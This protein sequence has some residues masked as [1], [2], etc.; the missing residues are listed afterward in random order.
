MRIPVL[1]IYH[2]L[3][4]SW[5]SLEQAEKVRVDH[6]D[7]LDLLNLLASVL[8]GTV[9][10]LVK[11]GLNGNYVLST[12][13]INGVKG[14]FEVGPTVKTL[15]H[16]KLRAICTF[17]EFSQDILLNRMI[18]SV[19]IRLLNTEGLDKEIRSKV[20][21]LIWHF[22]GIRDCDIE[23]KDFNRLRLG[24]NEK[25]YR[26][27][28]SL[29]KLIAGQLLPSEKAGEYHFDDFTRDEK[30]MNRLF[31][32]F[33]R[34]FYSC[35][36]GNEWSVGSEIIEWK[37]RPLSEDAKA[38]LPV[39]Q[40]DITIRNHRKKVIID[41]KYYQKTLTE[42][43]GSEKIRSGHLYQL[44]SYLNNQELSNDT[45]TQSA[46]GLLLY[47]KVN[48]T[49]DLSYTFGSHDLHIKT[50]DLHQD[51]QG[52]E[53]ELLNIWDNLIKFHGY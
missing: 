40:T 10:R 32:S 2:M 44:F 36:L 52:V 3:A 20:R 51:W 7:R 28:I 22:P 42:Y 12:D 18:V 27:V 1:N 14:K 29:C 34:N 9:R 15:A 11:R 33:V 45:V 39:M 38:F 46:S 30:K 6:A 24:K 5:R 21:S 26:F 37:L 17:D 13:E 4:Y 35:K 16:R 41:T 48:A 50:V 31:E 8:T 23:I 53:A 49:L 43:Y 19:L 25:H 47:P